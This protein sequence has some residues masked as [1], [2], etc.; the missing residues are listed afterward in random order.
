MARSSGTAHNLSLPPLYDWPMSSLY[1]QGPTEP[2]SAHIS[3]S[4]KWVFLPSGHA[5]FFFLQALTFI[6][7]KIPLCLLTYQADTGCCKKLEY[8]NREQNITITLPVWSLFSLLH[9]H[10]KM[11]TWQT[12]KHGEAF[13]SPFH[14]FT[15]LIFLGCLN[16]LAV[17][18][19][20]CLPNRTETSWVLNAKAILKFQQTIKTI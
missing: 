15:P 10:I 1:A 12:T 4:E 8:R 9:P 20:E 6:Q 18:A 11:L 2:K 7:T 19:C 14:S 5:W 17:C 16:Y 3:Y 13:L